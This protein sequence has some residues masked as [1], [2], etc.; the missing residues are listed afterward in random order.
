[1]DLDQEIT[2]DNIIAEPDNEFVDNSVVLYKR[3]HR[4]GFLTIK[5]IP[6]LP[7]MV[8]IGSIDPK[9]KKSISV[10]SCYVAGYKLATY[11]QAISQGTGALLYPEY[12]KDFDRKLPE[13]FA[14]YGGGR[15]KEGPISRIFKIHY[16]MKNDKPQLDRFAWKCGHFTGK[17]SD[18]GA[19]IADR[20]KPLS[21]DLIMVPRQEM[22]EISFL[23]N[24]R[25]YRQL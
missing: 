10:T 18:T 24:Q 20:S 14:V 17:E 16:W 7:L 19:F 23:L 22:A 1:M 2:E 12:P 9:T 13:S 6:D 25:K 8:E 11:L 5:E 21:A 4:R 15:S 3:W